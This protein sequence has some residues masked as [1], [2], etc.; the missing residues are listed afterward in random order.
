[1]AKT[2]FVHCIVETNQSPVVVFQIMEQSLRLHT[3]GHVMRNRNVFEVQNATKNVTMFGSRINGMVYITSP[4]KGVLEVNGEIRVVAMPLGVIF[5]VSLALCLPFIGA[6]LV[7][8]LLVIS[9]SKQPEAPFQSA[10]SDFEKRLWL[11]E[12]YDP[13]NPPVVG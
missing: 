11:A 10:L 13:N 12:R 4:Q 7:V 2:R 3:G 5:A 1:M 9:N 6:I 8:I